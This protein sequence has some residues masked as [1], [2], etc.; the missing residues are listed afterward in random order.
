MKT[1]VKNHSNVSRLHD[2]LENYQALGQNK[3]DVFVA[4]ENGIWSNYSVADYINN[5][6]SFSYG[7]IKLGLKPGDRVIVISNNRPE[8]NFIDMGISQ[9]GCVSVPLFSTISDREYRYI[10]THCKPKLIVVSDKSLYTR[11]STLIE[12]MKFVRQLYTIDD[13]EDTPNWKRILEL[14]EGANENIINQLKEQAKKVKPEDI[15]T[16]IYTSGTTGEPKGVLLSHKNIVSNLKD[17]CEVHP[18]R[19]EIKI[20]SFLPLC[21]MYERT[22]NYHFQ[23]LG[24]S[25]YYAE[26]LGTIIQNIQEIKPNIFNTVP[27]VLE[28]LY[29]KIIKKGEELTGVKQ[30]IY[31][32]AISFGL[33]SS[34][35]KG[36]KSKI[37]YFLYDRLVYSKW[38]KALGGNIK[39]IVSGGASISE[40][41]INV[42]KSAGLIVLEGYGLTEMAPV[43]TVNNYTNNEIMPGT[44]GIPFKS[45]QIKVNPDGEILCKGPGL[46][47]GYY[48]DEGLT[49]EVI[50]NEGWFHTGDIGKLIDN[51]FLKITDRK[52]AIFKL[53]NG[54]YISPQFIESKC[55]ESFYINN[56]YV[57]GENQK[58]VSA[59]LSPDIEYIS[60]WAME[61][62][63]DFKCLSELFKS[64]ML[65]KQIQEEIDY[66]NQGL[67]ENDK[68]KKYVLVSNEWIPGTGEL[69][70][71][72]KLKRHFLH[73][74]YSQEINEF[75]KNTV[76][77]EQV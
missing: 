47:Q 6:K 28:G 1:I 15:A 53:S 20:L 8:W 69:S 25:I 31:K 59:I 3:K 38:R 41:I 18:F 21:H 24:A 58:F 66:V 60:G 34:S 61:N 2:L 7:L 27:R 17:L 16:M 5:A 72:L 45:I 55:K 30:K 36:L 70:Q 11:I 39:F 73:K 43:V 75:Y 42:L 33:K 12:S 9:V 56:A 71:T 57:V 14:G 26:N 76:L 35:S 49:N 46:M 63:L 65:Q 29:K 67:N 50:D 74:K 37:R 64:P 19:K 40:D 68:V 62:D 48:N 52:K 44:V 77:S 22:V 23:Y 13:V 4:K 10:F 54:K 51:K 32:K